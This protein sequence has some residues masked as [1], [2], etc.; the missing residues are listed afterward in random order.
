M[1]NGVAMLLVNRRLATNRNTSP[2]T[3]ADHWQI[4]GTCHPVGTWYLRLWIG[5][6]EMPAARISTCHKKFTLK[7]SL[8]QILAPIFPFH[9]LELKHKGTSVQ[10]QVTY[11]LNL[12]PSLIFFTHKLCLKDQFSFFFL[13]R[14]LPSALM[15]NDKDFYF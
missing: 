5:T 3:P 15:A 12:L 8:T 2:H 10:R 9:Y 1:E 11:A 7:N 6:R 14:F 13:N 4:R